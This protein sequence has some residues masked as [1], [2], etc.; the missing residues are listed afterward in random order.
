MPRTNK[1]SRV[2]QARERRNERIK[3]QFAKLY[4]SGLRYEVVMEK[5]IDEFA[6]AENTIAQIINENGAYGKKK[7]ELIN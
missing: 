3:V 6:L 5:L 2:T 1:N 4:N 7:T